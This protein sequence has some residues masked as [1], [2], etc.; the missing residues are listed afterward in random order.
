MANIDIDSIISDIE[1]GIGSLA[2]NLVP[3]YVSEAEKDAGDFLTQ[4][5]ADLARWSQEYVDGK[6]SEDDFSN[7]LQGDE[8]LLKMAELT[9]AGIADAKMDSFKA[10]LFT[11]IEKVVSALI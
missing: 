4:I 7:L 11:V 8:D 10:G 6:I 2:A 3:G 9:K 1:D 5:K